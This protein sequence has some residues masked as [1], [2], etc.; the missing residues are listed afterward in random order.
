V[1]GVRHHR[2]HRLDSGRALER[3]ARRGWSLHAA[4]GCI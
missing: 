1:R 2:D 3:P 4:D